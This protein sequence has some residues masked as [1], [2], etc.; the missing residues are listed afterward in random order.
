MSSGLTKRM[1]IDVKCGDQAGKII[2]NFY[3]HSK[4][5]DIEYYGNIPD[6]IIN[7]FEEMAKEQPWF[8]CSVCY[9]SRDADL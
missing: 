5:I 4:T 2:L 9:T 1:E 7:D 6:H 3:R 8:D